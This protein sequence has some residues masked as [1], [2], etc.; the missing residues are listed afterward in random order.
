MAPIEGDKLRGHLAGL[1]LASLESGAA[2]GWEIWTRLE[3][4]GDGALR[5]KEGSLYPALYRLEQEGLIAARWEAAE[6][7]RRGPR[8]RIYRLT[9][10][11]RKRLTAARE[12]WRQF[13][14]VLG[15]LLG[16]TT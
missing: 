2:H 6:S 9:G 4:A 8:R 16:G 1:I 3:S 13:V 11:G 5:L 10:K 7:A 14:T 12:E 15:G